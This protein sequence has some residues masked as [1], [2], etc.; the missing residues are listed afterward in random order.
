MDARQERGVQLARQG[1]IVKQGDT[2]KVPDSTGFCG[3]QKRRRA[4]SLKIKSGNV[5]PQRHHKICGQA[6]S[7]IFNARLYQPQNPLESAIPWPIT[8]S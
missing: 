6:K 5:L 8:K 4:K 1:H 2:W 3:G 7:F